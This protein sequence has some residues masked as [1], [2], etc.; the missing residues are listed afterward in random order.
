MAGY[1]VWFHTEEHLPVQLQS[2]LFTNKYYSPHE[3]L[4]T[5]FLTIHAYVGNM[6]NGSVTCF[7]P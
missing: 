3:T 7:V 4:H 5:S 6:N 1:V 2:S